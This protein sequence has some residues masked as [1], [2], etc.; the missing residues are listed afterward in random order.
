MGLGK[1]SQEV[2]RLLAAEFKSLI[3]YLLNVAL[4]LDD[5]PRS[6]MNVKGLLKLLFSLKRLRGDASPSL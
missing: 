5:S 1:P 2:V 3:H 6:A 4:H